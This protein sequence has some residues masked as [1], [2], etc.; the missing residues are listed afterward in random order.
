MPLRARPRAH[1]TSHCAANTPNAVKLLDCL[2]DCVRPRLTE[3]LRPNA[4]A[5]AALLF[6]HHADRAAELNIN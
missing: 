4:S 6:T 5:L 3:T 1:I 2:A